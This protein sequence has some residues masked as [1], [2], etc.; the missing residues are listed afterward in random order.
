MLQYALQD[1][2]QMGAYFSKSTG[3]P[4]S[5]VAPNSANR[6]FILNC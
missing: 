5:T 3:E 4:E 1:E 6:A 2:D